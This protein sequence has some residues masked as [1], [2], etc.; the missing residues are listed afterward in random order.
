MDPMTATLALTMFLLAAPGPQG[1]L[2]PGPDPQIA[3]AAVPPASPGS[4]DDAQAQ[5]PPAPPPVQVRQADTRRRPSMVGYIEDATVRSQVRVRV[6]AG[7]NIDTPDRAEFFYAKC[8]CYQIDPPPFFDPEAPGPGPGVPTSLNFQ[9]FY[10]QGEY[11][12]RDGVSLFAELPIRSIQPQG[13]LDFG[14]AY[15]PFPDASG[16]GD[17][18]FG[19]KLALLAEEDRAVTL[20]ARMSL[21]TGDA[22]RGLGTSNVSLE[23][24]LLYQQAVTERLGI[25]AQFGAW[26]PFGGSEGVPTSGSDRFAGNVLF[27]GVGPAYDLVETDRVRFAP[28][29]EL[30]G[31]RV[32]GGAQTSCTPEGECTFTTDDNI[33][34]LKFGARALVDGRHSVYVGYGRA[35]TDA[36]WYRNVLRLEYR[37]GF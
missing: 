25:E 6:D 20:Q 31:W 13:F 10:V 15:A 32:I 5:P 14:P 24:A 21:P 33:V 27:Y 9:Q 18:R 7:T 8:G 12:F 2:P 30:V 4:E 16:L 17:I 23:P 19:A 29:L 35:L 37:L 34:N 22:A 11:L 1:L 26:L 3:L 28:V 36:W